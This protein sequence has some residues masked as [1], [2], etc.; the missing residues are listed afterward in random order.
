MQAAVQSPFASGES[1][2]NIFKADF[3]ELSLQEIVETSKYRELLSKLKSSLKTDLHTHLGGAIP[4]EFI[5]KYSIGQEYAEF[6]RF[7][8][9]LRSGMDYSEGFKAFSMIGKVLNSNKRIE[10]AAYEFCRTQ[11][12]DNVTFTELRTGLKR[13]DGNFE[14]YLDAV[15]AGLEK[16]MKDYPVRVTLVL[17]LRR[18]TSIEDANEIIDLAIKYRGQLLTGID[19][20]GESIKGDCSGIFEALKRAKSNGLP[21]TLHIG[22]NNLESSEQ[23]LRELTEIQPSRVGHAVHLCPEA[24]AWIEDKQ[25]VVEACIRSALSV[26]MISKPS[27]H[28]ALELFKKGHPVVFCTDDS[29]LF[30]DL[31]EELALVACLC[32]LSVAEVVEMQKRALA[33]AF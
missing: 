10:E 30:G 13:L 12:Y 24:R 1:I 11:N 16:G 4:I 15:I 3:T 26:S 28:P 18:E 20:S 21:I 27:Q 5:E 8:E 32:N 7:I 29:T 6:I 22:E 2:A 25:I 9:K 33:Y 14:D 19:V 17:S 23:Q 31:S